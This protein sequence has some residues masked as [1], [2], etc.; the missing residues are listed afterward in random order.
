MS[1]LVGALV[2][3]VVALVGARFSF[4]T[5][6]VPAGPRLLFRTGT[7]FLLIGFALGPLGLGLLTEEATRQ[8]FPVLG[9][10]LGWVGFH[11][12]LQLDRNA[13]AHFPLS[14]HALAL[15]QAA[16]TLVFFLVGGWALLF[17]GGLAHE[18]PTPLLLGAACTAA[19]TTPAGIAMVSANFLVKGPIR[20][21]LYLIG[22]LD[23]LVGIAALQVT[24][25]LYRPEVATA[26]A[27]GLAQLPL[28]GVALGLGLACG[29]LFLWLGRTRPAGE[30]VVLYLLGIC[31]FT[32]GAALQ[33]GLSPLFVSLTMGALVA[34]LGRDN[35]RILRV[36]ERWEKP[37]YLSF[38]LLAGALLRPTTAWVAIF[39]LGYAALRVGAKAGGTAAMVALLPLGERVPPSLGLG[40]IPQGGISLAMAVSGMLLYP[41]LSVRG[42]NAS[43]TLFTTV[44]LGVVISELVGPFLT[45]AVLKSAGEVS[46]WVERALEEGDPEGAVQRASGPENPS[47]PT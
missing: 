23:A 6:L 11:F 29:M 8:L 3:L 28:V 25:A 47:P 19:V 31:A 13:L 42:I 4:S 32:A 24:Y 40:L 44:V 1:P 16:L 12:G 33:W 7:H 26:A 27:G 21:L 46:P 5:E 36:L 22:S 14:Q 34:N 18:V 43:D 41:D 35:A 9:V 39:A 37:V 15:G 17:V 20:D 38:L 2:L 30:E 10:G 45:V